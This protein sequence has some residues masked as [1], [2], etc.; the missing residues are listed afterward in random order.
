[1]IECCWKKRTLERKRNLVAGRGGVEYYKSDF[2]CRIGFL[3]HCIISK[4]TYV[5]MTLLLCRLL[6]PR[7]VKVKLSALLSRRLSV[8]KC[9]S[10]N[11]FNRTLYLIEK[12]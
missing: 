11:D 12:P 4:R 1:M 3:D 7:S 5:D 9:F 8:F 2:Y 10:V 6:E